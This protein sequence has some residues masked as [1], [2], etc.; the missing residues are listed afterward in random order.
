M[1][2]LVLG[3]AL[4]LAL[5]AC[6]GGGGSSD[7]A[8]V[9]QAWSSFF[10]TKGSV[11]EHV[12]LLQNGPKFR[13]AIQGF[14]S[15]PLASGAKSTVDSVTLQGPNKAKVVYDVSVGGVSLGKQTG[16]AYKVGDKWKVGSASLC[17]LISLSGSTPP[18]CTS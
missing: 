16:Y 14:L 18:A 5:A 15:N 3:A 6:G 2:R 13:S 12:A 1:K 10:S 4:V 7:A 9:K 8:Q 17:Q 11:D